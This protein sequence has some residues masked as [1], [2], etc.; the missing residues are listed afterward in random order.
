[1][2]N[3]ICNIQNLKVIFI[4]AYLAF[5]I[6]SFHDKPDKVEAALSIANSISE[7]IK[8]IN[9]T[10]IRGWLTELAIKFRKS[11]DLHS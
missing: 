10:P 5:Q 7:L 3:S 6:H 4:L 11:N 2:K 9:E 1:M 8:E